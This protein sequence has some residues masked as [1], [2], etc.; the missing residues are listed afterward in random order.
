MCASPQ[1]FKAFPTSWHVHEHCCKHM[2]M[3]VRALHMLVHAWPRPAPYMH[4]LMHMHR[5]QADAHPSPTHRLPCCLQHLEPQEGPPHSQGSFLLM[6][7]RAPECLHHCQK[8]WLLI[9]QDVGGPGQQRLRQCPTGLRLSPHASHGFAPCFFQPAPSQ[10]ASPARFSSLFALSLQW[11][12]G[13][14]GLTVAYV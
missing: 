11:S 14:S 7:R 6:Q 1:L 10:H 9:L 2:R 3:L 13:M 5:W 4:L 12:R 8:A